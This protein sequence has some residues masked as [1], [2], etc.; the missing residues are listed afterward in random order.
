MESM[1]LKDVFE[2]VATKILVNVDL[3]HKGSNQ[4][5][6]GGVSSLRQFFGT[7]KK[8][9]KIRIDWFYFSDDSDVKFETS[10]MTFYDS[11]KDNPNRSAEWR[12]YYKGNFLANA[13]EN[14]VLILARTQDRVFGLVFESESAWL[15]SA[16]TLFKISD[17]SATYR[18][19]S[20]SNL[21]LSLDFKSQ[22]ILETLGIELLIPPTPSD[23]DLVIEAFKRQFPTTREMSDFALAQ[24]DVDFSKP[25]QAIIR[26]LKREEE[27]FRA[28][29]KVIVE[30][31]L[32]KGFRD[33]DAFIAF[34]LS[35][36]NR[37]KSR[38]GFAFENHLEVIF[39]RHDLKFDREK[40][41]ENRKK[42]DFIFPSI[43]AYHDLGFPAD[44]LTMLGVKS[45]CKDRWRQVLSEADRIESKHLCT[46]ETSISVNQTDEMRDSKLTLVVPEELH[47]TYTDE[48]RTQL[49]SLSR[50]IDFVRLR[51]K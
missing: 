48:Q 1:Y 27:L 49:Y 51:Q 6:V 50:F 15:R 9:E 47:D 13:D 26:L 7:S 31:R 20:D 45:T 34:S 17:F 18:T 40:V 19:F 30:E 21:A 44:Q 4:H 11:R 25:D 24:V 36:N 2:A 41:T 37:R 8:S 43:D 10:V 42:P 5:E 33:V 35:V 38:M 39:L 28:L 16:K 46:L 3:P 29:E 32:V 12:L 23:E 14:D 22:L